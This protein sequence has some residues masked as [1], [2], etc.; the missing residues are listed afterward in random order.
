MPELLIAGVVS[1]CGAARVINQ[2]R[3]KEMSKDFRAE[4]FNVYRLEL[5]LKGNKLSY[6]VNYSLQNLD[7]STFTDIHFVGANFKGADMAYVIF[8]SC[9]FEMCSFEGAD[10]THTSFED[11]IFDVQELEGINYVMNKGPEFD[12]CIWG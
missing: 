7:A 1:L 8:K 4:N 2:P 5:S 10:L 3:R 11:C 6:K 12:G 9:I